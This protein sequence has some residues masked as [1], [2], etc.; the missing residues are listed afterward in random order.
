MAIQSILTADYW[1]KLG[2]A[3]ASLL[4]LLPGC[5]KDAAPAESSRTEITLDLSATASQ[6]DLQVLAGARSSLR[7]LTFDTSGATPKI[8]AVSGATFRSHAFFRK[9]GAAFVGYGTITWTALGRDA[10]GL[11]QLEARNVTIT[12][13]NTSGVEPQPGEQ[14]YIA[15][16]LGGGTLDATKT[17]V[18]F[19]YD[20]ALD[21]AMQ[22]N[23][24]RVPLLSPWTPITIVQETSGAMRVVCDAQLH[25][26]PQGVLYRVE[27]TNQSGLSLTETKIRLETEASS[28]LGAFDFSLAANPEASIQT[29]TYQSGFVHSTTA[30]TVEY[31]ER[32]IAP[33]ASGAKAVALAWGMPF[34]ATAADNRHIGVFY[35]HRYV[36]KTSGVAGN[37]RYFSPVVWSTSGTQSVNGKTVRLTGNIGRPALPIEY[38]AAS[39]HRV[40]WTKL[41]NDIYGGPSNPVYTTVPVPLGHEVMGSNVWFLPALDWR[42][43]LFP[44]ATTGPLSGDPVQVLTG[45]DGDELSFL[46]QGYDGFYQ[47]YQD[48]T[49][50]AYALLFTRAG[51]NRRSAWHWKPSSANDEMT[52]TARWLGASD[53]TPFATIATSAY[54][55]SGTADDISITFPTTPRTGIATGWYG[56]YFWVG[57][58]GWTR[59]MSAS[60]SGS[61]G[62]VSHDGNANSAILIFG[63][64][65]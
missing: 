5:T 35:P 57:A 22:P 14:W 25:F 50:G 44:G 43:N 65:Y 31:M 28:T 42:Y 20:Q 52:I 7:S 13:D 24:I 18:D 9:V 63:S 39:F 1:P 38:F 59:A 41:Y 8:S 32:P 58:S 40:D 10:Q 49:P 6:E 62:G 60:S 19:A 56:T 23:E 45:P 17:K 4:L 33:V 53:A 51:D 3:A 15:A 47:S 30:G 64:S 54:W 27:L 46:G 36:K 2:L 11:I 16:I 55:A 26:Q 29:G 34:D 61:F 12:L 37:M 48:G 21:M